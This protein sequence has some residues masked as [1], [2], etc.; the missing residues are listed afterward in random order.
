MIKYDRTGSPSVAHD[1]GEGQ[2]PS[3]PVF[4]PRTA[5]AAE[6]GSSRARL[7]ARLRR[8]EGPGLGLGALERMAGERDCPVL[9]A[10]SGST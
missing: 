4:V 7:D 3:E 8:Y 2:F 9:A 1:F 10:G 6:E 5:A